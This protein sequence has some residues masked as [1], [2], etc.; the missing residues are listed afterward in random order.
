IR[1]IIRTDIVKGEEF[2]ERLKRIMKKYREGLVDNAETLDRFA[3]I[4]DVVKD[5]YDEY[6]VANIQTT[7]EELLKLAKEAIALE[8]EHE[9]LGLTRAEMAFYHAVSNPDKVQ[10]F[11]TDDQLILLTKELTDSIAEEMTSDWMMRE[12]GRANVRR[13]IKRLLKKYQYPGNYKEAIQ[14]V[15]KQAEHWDGMQ[16]AE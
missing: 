10:D 5:D 12:S 11:Y 6:K 1:G 13:T 4:A 7:R 16:I 2:S 9:S 14:L 3:G 8:K 15:I